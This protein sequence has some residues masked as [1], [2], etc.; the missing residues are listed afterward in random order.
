MVTGLW[1]DAQVVLGELEVME[2]NNAILR[3]LDER[4]C[5]VCM[6]HAK[7]VLLLPC[8]HMCMCKACTDKVLAGS[9]QCPV[10]REHVVDS[11]EAFF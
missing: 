5:V 9:G 7:K 11:L 1:F 6:V 2:K 3:Q 4:L 10:C 8:K